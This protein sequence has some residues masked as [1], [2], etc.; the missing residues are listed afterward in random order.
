MATIGDH[1]AVK[2]SAP[3]RGRYQHSACANIGT[4]NKGDI[5]PLCAKHSCPN[6]GANWVLKRKLLS[7]FPIVPETSSELQR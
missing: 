1:R 2:S 3:D 4:F 7:G 5:L 6:R